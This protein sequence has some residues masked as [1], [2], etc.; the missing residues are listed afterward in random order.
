MEN[1]ERALSVLRGA[2]E[3]EVNGQRFYDEAARHCIDPWAKETFSTLA[4]EEEEHT[5]LLLVQ[6]GALETRGQWLD[7][8]TAWNTP[9][10]VD[11]TDLFFQDERHV[12][13]L[14][15][16]DQSVGETVDRR[17]DDLSALVFGLGM[18]QKAIELYEEQLR[19]TVD[20]GAQQ[21]YE[22]LV[23]QE[24]EHYDEL[25]ARWETL[26]GRSFEGQPL[27]RRPWK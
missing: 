26:A 3:N 22:Y 19:I 4:R 17:L 14:F 16:P 13:S 21:A 23:L 15:S 11:V 27:P 7:L 18:E 5:R 24:R 25:K 12:P 20:S 9:L 8:E 10:T 1:V 2:I 6:Y